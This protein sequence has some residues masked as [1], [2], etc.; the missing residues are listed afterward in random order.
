MSSDK[1]SIAFIVET[2]L[3]VRDMNQY[4]TASAGNIPLGEDTPF[5]TCGESLDVNRWGVVCRLAVSVLR[6]LQLTPQ[7]V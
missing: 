2:S 1:V 6:H 5:C 7:S 4:H 3:V